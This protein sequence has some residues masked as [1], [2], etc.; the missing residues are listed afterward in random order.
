VFYKASVLK[1]QGKLDE[2]KPLFDKAANLAPAQF[3]DQINREANPAP[4]PEVSPSGA[5]TGDAPADAPKSPLDS[6]PAEPKKP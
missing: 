2:A 6:K 3:K 5:P 4:S 1:E